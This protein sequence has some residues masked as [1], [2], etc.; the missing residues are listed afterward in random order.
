MNR[1][2]GS[3][4]PPTQGTSR[5]RRRL[6]GRV[7]WISFGI[8]AALHVFAIVWYALFMQPMQPGGLLLPVASSAGSAASQGI[9]VVH[10]VETNQ[11]TLP[12]QR[13]ERPTVPEVKPQMAVPVGPVTRQAGGAAEQGAENGTRLSAA[14]RLR[15][16]PQ[17]RRLWAPLDPAVTRLTPQQR[18]QLALAGRLEAWRDSVAAADSAEAALTD[19][20]F[21]DKSGKKWGVTPGQLHLGGLTLPLP[22]NFGSTPWN[23]I[24][25]EGRSWE[26]NDIQRHA[27]EGAVRQDWKARARAIRER[28]DKERA[29]AKA[30]KADSSGVKH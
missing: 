23:R 6:N 13:P 9:Q 21:T 11:P 20:T 28:R 10:I 26:W 2:A 22:F 1:P 4:V 8:S 7:V 19:W 15:P 5:S 16:H 18:M 14:E 25:N 24:Q 17:N 3:V 12:Q 27:A 30:A 29:A